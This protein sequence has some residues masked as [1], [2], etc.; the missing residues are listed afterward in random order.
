MSASTFILGLVVSSCV[1]LAACGSKGPADTLG[2]TLRLLGEPG[3]PT[4]PRTRV[5]YEALDAA[6]R[7]AV[8]RRAAALS[9]KLGR[10]VDVDEAIQYRGFDPTVR[11]S[12]IEVEPIDAEHARLKVSLARVGG[13]AEGLMPDPV[14]FDAVLEDGAW[15]LSMPQLAAEVVE[16]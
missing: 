15:K 6:S 14:T 3:G 16:P 8:D 5:L 12:T 10:P 11:V 4:V 9:D 2:P 7:Q 13:G 1:A